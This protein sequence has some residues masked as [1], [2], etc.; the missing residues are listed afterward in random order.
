MKKF[1]SLLV[2]FTVLSNVFVLSSIRTIAKHS[3]DLEQQASSEAEI[4]TAQYPQAIYLPEATQRLLD[5]KASTWL[6]ARVYH[7]DDAIK[8]VVKYFKAQS[9]KMNKT[10]EGNLLLQI[11]LRDNWK[12]R[13]DFVRFVSAIFGVGSEF[14]TST[15]LEE[16]ETS[17]GVIVLEDSMVKVLMMSPHPSSANNN[18][19]ESGTMIIMIRERLPAVEPLRPPARWRIISLDEGVRDSDIIIIG[20]LTNIAEEI[21]SIFDYGRGELIVDEVLWGKATPGQKL[22]LVWVNQPVVICPRLE[23]RDHQNKPLVWLLKQQSDGKV[24]ADNPGRFVGIEQKAPVVKLVRKKKIPARKANRKQPVSGPHFA[25]PC[26]L[27]LLPLMQNAQQRVVQ[28]I[29]AEDLNGDQAIAPHESEHS[30]NASEW[31]N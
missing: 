27:S 12:I 15:L 17:F 25:S 26:E 20:R 10:A 30:E 23:H 24:R 18:K 5:D 21:T 1:R 22:P 6:L 9:Q 8:D 7:T 4:G 16:T 3:D 28:M 11:L 29:F 19:L 13:K 14:R 31:L 2:C